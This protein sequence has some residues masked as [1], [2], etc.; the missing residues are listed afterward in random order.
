MNELDEP[1]IISL[2]LLMELEEVL[3]DEIEEE[4]I[5][6]QLDWGRD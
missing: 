3:D 6:E 5:W 4:L 1:E 2:D